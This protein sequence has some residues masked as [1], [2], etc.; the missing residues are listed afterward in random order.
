MVLILSWYIVHQIKT[1]LTNMQQL[2]DF[3]SIDSF[4]SA[5]HPKR[6]A[7]DVDA[8]YLCRPPKEPGTAPSK[9][10]KTPLCYAQRGLDHS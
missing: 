7:I 6:Y 10:A 5:I 9:K 2:A 1:L 3:T 4:E 8:G